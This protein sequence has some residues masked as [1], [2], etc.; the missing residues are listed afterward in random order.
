MDQF[1]GKNVFVTGINGFI[2]H[3]VA[4]MLEREGARVIGLRRVEL[5]HV[6]TIS[7]KKM[8]TGDI[9]DYKL[10]REIISANEI[11]IIFHF[12]A[13]S[14]VRISAR[15]PLTAYSTNV[16]GTATLLEAARNVGRC[17]KI[18]VASSDKAYGDHTELPYKETHALRAKNTYDTSKACADLIAQSFAHNYK[19]PVIVTRCSNVYGTMDP[20][21]SRIIPN[22]IIR[23]ARGQ[24]PQVRPQ[25]FKMER[26]FIHVQDVVDA[27]REL[28]FSD[29][30]KGEFNIGGTGPIRP[31]EVI[32]K[33]AGIM[34]KDV[35]KTE[36]IDDPEFC[37]I[38]KQYIDASL[39]REATGWTPKVP[40]DAGLRECVE[41][42][43]RFA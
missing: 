18:L 3:H 40:L 39:L 24:N 28:A 42:Y 17:Q 4:K 9:T 27:Y 32:S 22:T 13:C 25:F 30:Q 10:L 2:G 31:I 34:K 11:D 35:S 37:E 19:M 14:I 36:I 43:S 26:E 5:N 12:A 1:K 16:M 8:Y 33:I 20:N 23:L 29:I 38:E 6:M 15:D 7:A 21:R 41:Y